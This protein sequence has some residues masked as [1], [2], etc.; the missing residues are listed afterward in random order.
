MSGS[1]PPP[2][3]EAAGCSETVDTPERARGILIATVLGSSLSFVMASI[4]NVALPTMQ[5][6]FGTDAAGLQWIVNAYLLPLA[7]L[8]LLGGA[9][10]DRIGRRRGFLIGLALFLAASIACLVSPSLATLLAARF[11]QGVGAALLAPNS[12]AIIADT[13]SGE[14]RGRA[15]GTWAAAGA[16]AGALAPVAGGFFVDQLGWRWAFGIV[17]PAAVAALIVG[18][19]AIPASR[20]AREN[21]S[22]LDLSGAVL[23]TG[24]L[25]ALVYALIIL[26]ER[27]WGDILVIGAGAAGLALAGGFLV[28][29][30][31]AK[32]PMMPLGIFGSGSF[33]G[34]SI[35][36]FLLYGALGGLLVLLPYVLINGS[37]YSATRAG[38]ALLPFPLVMGVLSRSMGG[39]A[40]RVGIRK[41]LTVGPVLVGLGFVLFAV[42]GGADRSYWAAFLP[43]LL[44]MAIG[45]AISVAPLTTAVMNAVGE[46]YVGVASGINNA[47]S[48]AAGLVA[49]ALLGL[50]LVDPGATRETFAKA[51]SSASIVGAALAFAAAL[52]SFVMV[53]EEAVSGDVPAR[54]N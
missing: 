47:I 15:V 6:D 7:A 50:V 51:F 22:S 41:A 26:P 16:V 32:E 34:I 53:R 33:S 38:A 8:V 28:V 48:R 13:F 10:G 9:L 4:V 45:M 40:T 35:L 27:R 19:K 18:W 49:T 46:A 43:G 12:L 42:L 31:R 14:E 1:L 5:A 21:G 20:G 36:T 17:V 24:A 44:V 23:A 3:D 25:F 11:V 52:A 2:C 54:G 39:L 37:G 30:H 29:E